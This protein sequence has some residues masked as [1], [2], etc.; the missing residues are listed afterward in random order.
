LRYYYNF[1]ISFSGPLTDSLSIDS[2]GRI[3]VMNIKAGGQFYV[4]AVAE[5][6]GDNYKDTAMVCET[7]FTLFL[8]QYVMLQHG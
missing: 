7:T 4:T 6:E 1:G 3:S 2:E 5:I 8:I